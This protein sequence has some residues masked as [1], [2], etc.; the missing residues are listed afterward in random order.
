MLWKRKLLIG[1]IWIAVSMVT[2]AALQQIPAV[3]MA[4]ALVMVNSQKIPDRY[5]SSTVVA[6]AQD[7]LATLSMEI[8]SAKR[9]YRGSCERD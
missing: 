9:L 2:V 8:L 1:L 4:T 3:Y 6:D 5:V 7:R